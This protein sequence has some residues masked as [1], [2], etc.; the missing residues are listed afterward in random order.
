MPRVLQVGNLLV[1]AIDD[2]KI[3]LLLT[4]IQALQIGWLTRPLLRIEKALGRS[5]AYSAGCSPLSR[6]ATFG[7]SLLSV[8]RTHISLPHAAHRTAPAGLIHGVVTDDHFASR[9]AP[10]PNRFI[11]QSTFSGGS[12]HILGCRFFYRFRHLLIRVA[13]QLLSCISLNYCIN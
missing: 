10:L 1:H 3:R 6:R 9:T 2:L 5:S 8:F 4:L 12:V 7:T 11:L 13:E